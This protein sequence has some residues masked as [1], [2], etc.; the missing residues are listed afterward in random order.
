MRKAGRD[1][2]IAFGDISCNHPAINSLPQLE[3]ILID[4]ILTNDVSGKT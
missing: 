1:W 4:P 2:V 3:G